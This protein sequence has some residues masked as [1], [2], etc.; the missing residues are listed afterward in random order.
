MHPER[1]RAFV[2]MG[3][4][5]GGRQQEPLITTLK[6]GYG[7][8]SFY[9]LYFQEEGVAEAEL[10]KDPRGFLSRVYTSPDTPLEEPTLTDPKASAGGLFPRLGA[11]KELPAWLK[12]EDLDYYVGQFT[13]S[14]FR[15][16]INFYRNLQRFWEVSQQLEEE[17]VKQPV[18]FIAGAKDPNI[19][20]ANA[21]QLTTMLKGGTTDL[22]G[23]KLFP[24]VGHWVQQEVADETNAALIK[25]FKELE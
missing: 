7:D 4:P 13:K 9:I 22:R 19:G 21:E 25:F 15:G 24:N 10:D 23:V 3:A 16:G 8:N 18:L 6:R 2:A 11:P 20:G 14:G 17:K 12:P 5:Y 1:F